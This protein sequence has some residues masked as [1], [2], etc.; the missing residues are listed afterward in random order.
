M[1]VVPVLVAIMLAIHHVYQGE[2]RELEVRREVVLD[3]HVARSG[4]SWPRPP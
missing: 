1:I 4:W 2:A 3:R